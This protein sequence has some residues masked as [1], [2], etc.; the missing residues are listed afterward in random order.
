MPE[1]K[2]NI[3]FYDSINSFLESTGVEHRTSNP[4]F[5][6]MRL[7]EHK[8]D[9]YRSPFRR[10]FYFV[11]L[12]ISN[13]N[14]QVGYN[15]IEENIKESFLVFQSPRQVYSFFRDKNTEGYLIYFKED[16]F[17]FFK[18]DFV[19]EFPFFDTLNTNLFQLT[20]SHYANIAPRFE[21][22]FLAYEASQSIYNI[23]VHKFFALLYQLKEFEIIEQQKVVKLPNAQQV[24]TKKFIQLI[25]L[26]Y[27]TKRTVEEYADLLTVSVSHLSKSV[28]TITGLT[29]LTL[30]ND[31]IT[32]EAKLM[33]KH[34]DLNIAEIAF[35]L[36]FSDTSN[37]GK[38]FRKQ[39]G[40][41]PLS[42][43]SNEK[44][45]V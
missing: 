32:K 41:S 12:L 40:T 28:K 22:V 3:P 42:F 20:Q 45:Q 13:G 17:H 30:I 2:E 44:E 7:A 43:R 39:T 1:E 9:I 38:F 18:P 24:L 31:R 25:N 15:N 19:Q 33:I 26:H 37:F 10:G 23:A 27:L 6:C 8:G 14:T 4:L 21:E 5:Y 34:T 11:A 36:N 16:S 29:V 35:Q